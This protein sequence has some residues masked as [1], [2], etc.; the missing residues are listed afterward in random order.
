MMAS[1]RYA[2]YVI[3]LV[4]LVMEEQ[5]MIV[6]LVNLIA[7]LTGQIIALAI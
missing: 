4:W 2:K 6:Y 7:H 1:T 5:T 3:V